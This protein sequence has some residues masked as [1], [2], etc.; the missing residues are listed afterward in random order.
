MNFITNSLW[1]LLVFIIKWIA[2]L[3]G[4]FYLG[5]YFYTMSY[6]LKASTKAQEVR[7]QNQALRLQAYE[8]M[9]LFCER[10]SIPQLLYRLNASG[11]SATALRDSML[12]AIQME[13]EHNVTQQIFVST[14]LWKIISLAKD[15]TA[16]NIQRAAAELPEDASGQDLVM[17]L[18]ELHSKSEYNANQKALEAITQEVSLIV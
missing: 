3:G 10:I 1:E 14:K 18:S 13:Y 4:L 17:K 11:I 15:D 16:Y 5:R 8:R 12:V 6:R 9:A 2:I 7:V